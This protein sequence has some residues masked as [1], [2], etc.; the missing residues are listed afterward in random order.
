[1]TGSTTREIHLG[2]I[3]LMDVLASRDDLLICEESRLEVEQQ[4]D[5][6]REVLEENG[7]KISII[8]KHLFRAIHPG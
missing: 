4:L 8:I 7:L 2:I 1:M 3:H 5:R 6:W